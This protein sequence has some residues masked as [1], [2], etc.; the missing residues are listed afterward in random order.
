MTRDF[1]LYDE[2]PGPSCYIRVNKDGEPIAIILGNDVI[3]ER[4]NGGY[5]YELST[6][7]SIEKCLPEQPALKDIREREEEEGWIYDGGLVWSRKEDEND[8]G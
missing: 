6:L 8:K 5:F 4:D 1:G 2:V 7:E 3:T